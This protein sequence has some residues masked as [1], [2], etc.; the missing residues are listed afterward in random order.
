M[1]AALELR[2]VTKRF[3]EK[4]AVDDLSLTINEGDFVGLLGRNGAGKSTTL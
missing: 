3:G 1:P 2:N 4:V